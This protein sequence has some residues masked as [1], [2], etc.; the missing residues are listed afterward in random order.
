MFVLTHIGSFLSS[1]PWISNPDNPELLPMVLTVLIFIWYTIRI[2]SISVQREDWRYSE[3]TV[4]F[5]LG[6]VREL[7]VISTSSIYPLIGG[8]NLLVAQHTVTYLFYPLWDRKHCSGQSS[9][10][11]FFLSP[12]AG[13][14]RGS[15]AAHHSADT[16]PIKISPTRIPNPKIQSP[17]L[18]G[19][20]AAA[21]S[22]SDPRQSEPH[23]G[24]TLSIMH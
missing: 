13:F 20:G 6:L 7:R 5:Y 10:F 19:W 11:M 16:Y 3:L 12:K 17:D 8:F 21:L 14:I 4:A 2:P 1:Y 9:L 22:S 15:L 24:H 18:C 23:V